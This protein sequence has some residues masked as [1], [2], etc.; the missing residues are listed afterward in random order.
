MTAKKTTRKPAAGKKTTKKASKKTGTKKAPA[1]KAAATKK[2]SARKDETA[3]KPKVS[4]LSVNMSHVFSLRPRA[5]TS[6]KQGDFQKAKHELQDTS[7]KTIH[8]AAL[9]VAERALELTHESGSRLGTRRR[10]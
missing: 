1:K 5:N 6:F 9:A 3:K 7:Y 2:T 10:F 8:E 4:S